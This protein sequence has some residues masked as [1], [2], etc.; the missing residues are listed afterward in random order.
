MLPAILAIYLRTALRTERLSVR[1]RSRGWVFLGAKIVL[2]LPVLYCGPLL[3]AHAFAAGS[4][5]SRYDLQTFLTLGASPLAAFWIVDDQ[6]Q[7]CPRCLRRL[8]NPARVGERSRSFLS[9]SGIEYVCTEG[10]GLL[11]VPDYPTS[12]FASQR[13]LPL[14]ASWRVLFQHGR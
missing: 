8:T 6:R 13:W 7:R 4:L 3:I 2:L 11:H 9:F 10:H 5:D 12:W 14:D 1:L